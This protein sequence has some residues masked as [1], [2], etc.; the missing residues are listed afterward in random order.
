MGN[1]SVRKLNWWE[2]N[3]LYPLKFAIS[4]R[5]STWGS[6]LVF[7]AG[8]VVFRIWLLSSPNSQITIW[9]SM[10]SNWLDP[11]NHIN[12]F[13]QFLTLFVVTAVWFAQLQRDWKE[14]LEKYL[15][16]EFIFNDKVYE[17]LSA[18]YAPLISTADIRVLGQS[19]GQVRN[20]NKQLPLDSAGNN[21]QKS[22]CIDRNQDVSCHP[23]WHFEITM[24]LREPLPRENKAVGIF[25]KSVERKL[26]IIERDQA[27]QSEAKLSQL[28]CEIDQFLDKTAKEKGGREEDY[29]DN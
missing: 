29:V 22:L 28:M 20:N 15:S 18:K 6:L 12:I 27:E 16:V 21:L 2:K 14:S 4:N 19:M 26:T 3:I 8:Y 23:F 10:R 17:H 5:R 9:N 11:E 13:L 7:S 24:P 25:L 1:N